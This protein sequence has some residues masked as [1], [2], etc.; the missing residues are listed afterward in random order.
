[1][2][3]LA[4]LAAG[5][6]SVQTAVLDLV[7]PERLPLGGYTQ[8]R[9]AL[10]DWGGEKLK[11]RTLVLADTDTRIAIVS[12]EL[13]TIPES[14]DREVRRRIPEDVRLFLTATHTH[15]APDSQMLNERM[16]FAV[17]GIASFRERWLTWYADRIAQC[18]RAAL[19]SPR[20]RFAHLDIAS[21]RLRMNRGRRLGAA[22]ETLAE[23]LRA[24]NGGVLLAHYAAHPTLFTHEQRRLDGDWIGRL[25]RSIGAPVLLG[26]IGDVA[27]S[28]PGDDP[29]EQCAAFVETFLRDR[30]RLGR[31]IGTSPLDYVEVPITLDPPRPHPEFAASFGLPDALAA[32][33]NERFAP[34]SA[35]VNAWRLGKMAV[36]GVPGEPTSEVGRRIALHGLGLGFESVWVVS[37]VGG[38]IGYVLM[39]ED[40]ARGGYEAT[41]SFHGPATALRLSRAADEALERLARRK[42]ADLGRHLVESER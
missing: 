23:E 7:P 14:L 9:G 41:L 22:P 20:A 34:S 16:T 36:V 6:I 12:A 40:Y 26:A 28:A 37:H 15:C 13:L 19:D 32:S 31:P 39:P 5:W 29:A 4:V 24:P 21:F 1:M 3:A 38:W 42:H 17:P 35:K 11:V 25:A 10:F 8:R 33:L 27:P 30:P 2:I 18:V